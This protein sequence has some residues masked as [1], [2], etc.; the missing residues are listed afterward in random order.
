M[1][2]VHNIENEGRQLQTYNI[3]IILD[4]KLESTNDDF[5]ADGD[6]CVY[7]SDDQKE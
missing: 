6:S 3:P 5:Q 2:N 7:L 1:P 4:E